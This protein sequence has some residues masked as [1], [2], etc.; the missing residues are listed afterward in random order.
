MRNQIRVK[1]RISLWLVCVM[2]LSMLP[3]NL[4]EAAPGSGS[5]DEKRNK[6][7]E[8]SGFVYGENHL[9]LNQAEVTL[10]FKKS[11]TETATT[12]SNGKFQFSNVPKGNGYKIAIAHEGY[13]T[14][15]Q[16]KIKVKSGKTTVLGTI[17]MTLLGDT[18]GELDHLPLVEAGQPNAVVIV[19]PVEESDENI[20]YAADSLTTYIE[21]STGALLPILTEAELSLTSEY[22]EHIH[23]FVGFASANNESDIQQQLIAMD[24][25]G[26]LIYP[27]ENSVTI[28]GPSS[29]G[30]RFGVDGFLEQYVG[31]RWLMPGEV[32]EDVPTLND[33]S[34][35]LTIV[36]NEPKHMARMISKQTFHDTDVWEKQ[37]DW[38]YHNGWHWNF[39]FH[40]N[41]NVILPISK[42]GATNP[43]FYP[44]VNGQLPASPH[45]GWNPCFT[46]PGIVEESIA[47]IVEYF[48]QHPDQRSYSL[49]VNDVGGFCEADPN[50]PQYPGEY[51]DFGYVDLSNIYYTWVN[52]VVEGVREVHPDKWFGLLAYRE[53]INAPT[54]PGFQ[55]NDHVIPYITSESYAWADPE[56][57]ADRKAMFDDWGQVSENLGWYDYTWGT[58]YML[59][60]VYPQLIGE[61][62]D[63]LNE[64]GTSGIYSEMYPNFAGEGPKPWLFMKLAW[65]P[66]QDVDTLLNEWYQRAVGPEAA[67]DLKAYFD[68]WEQFW[69]ETVPGGR[70]FQ[71]GKEQVYFAYDS[72]EYL[73]MVDDNDVALSRALLESVVDKAQTDQQRARANLFL[74]AFDYYEASALSYPRN[75]EQ[76][77]D[78]NEAISLLNEFVASVETKIQLAETR[79]ALIEA[80]KP[81]PNLNQP[82][83]PEKHGLL[84]SGWNPNALWEV[85]EY[86]LEMEPAGGPVTQRVNEL[87]LSDDEFEA[88]IGELLQAVASPG[89]IPINANPSFEQ[90][91]GGGSDGWSASTMGQAAVIER[92]SDSSAP[93]RS[94]SA[95]VYINNVTSGELKQTISIQPGLVT[96]QL[97]YF[98]PL[99]AEYDL[100][101]IQLVFKY[102]DNEGNV[103]LERGSERE[104]LSVAA[105]SWE[106]LRLLEEVPNR[107]D[108]KIPVQ[109]QVILKMTNYGGGIQQLYVDDAVV[110]WVPNPPSTGIEGRIIGA[111]TVEIVGA[112]VHFAGQT[113]VTDSE[114]YYSFRQVE[115]GNGYEVTV[116]RDGYQPVTYESVTVSVDTMSA[117]PDLVMLAQTGA[118]SGTVVDEVGAAVGG[119]F[120]QVSGTNNTAIADETGSF[121]LLNVPVGDVT[122]TASAPGYLAGTSETVT[123]SATEPGTA[124]VTVKGIDQIDWSE[125]GADSFW[126]LVSYMRTYEP[127]GGSVSQGVDQLAQSTDSYL[128]Q[129]GRLLKSVRP[130]GNPTLN[131]N[132]SFESGGIYPSGWSFWAIPATKYM[133]RV[134]GPDVPI[135]SGGASVMI[136]G[137]TGGGLNQSMGIQPGLLAGQLQFYTSKGVPNTGSVKI[138]IQLY[139]AFDHYL[140]VLNSEESYFA[141]TTGTWASARF[142]QNIPETI[143]VAVPVKMI[144]ILKLTDYQGGVN[145]IFIDDAEFYQSPPLEPSG[146]RGTVIGSDT[147]A[148]AG[149]T[150]SINGQS[151]T[152]DIAGRYSLTG[153]AVGSGYEVVIEKDGYISGQIGSVEIT[154]EEMTDLAAIV[155]EQ[156]KGTINGTVVNAAQAPVAN[157]SVTV[158]GTG[159]LATSDESGNYVIVNVPVG[160]HTVTA[161]APGYVEGHSAVVAVQNGGVHTATVPVVS[162]ADINWGEWD[163][164]SFWCVV[165]YLRTYEPTGGPVSDQADQLAGHSQFDLMRIGQLLQVVRPGGGLPINANPSFETPGDWPPGWS[166]WMV[167]GTAEIKRASGTGVPVYTGEASAW[168]NGSTGGGPNQTMAI[169]PGFLSGQLRYYTS[170]GLPNGGTI[171][172]EAQLFDSSDTLLEVRYSELKPFEETKGT[173]ATLRL[174]E[175][176]P[177]LI[178][179]SPPVK[180]TLIIKLTDASGGVN[181]L[182]IDDAEFYQGPYVEE[183][184]GSIAG[185][186]TTTEGAP[187]PGAVVSIFG[188][189]HTAVTDHAGNYTLTD[190]PPGNY[191]VTSSVA[192]YLTGA[193]A[194]VEVI[195]TVITSANITTSFAANMQWDADLFWN[196]VHYV[197]SYEPSGGPMTSQFAALASSSDSNEQRIGGLLQD[198]GPGGAGPF[199]ANP[200]FEEPGDWPLGWSFWM[201]PVE[202]TI[203][204][205]SGEGVP[206]HTGTASIRVDGSTGG[207]PNQT[208]MIEPGLLAG[209]VYFYTP[210]GVMSSGSIKLELQLFDSQNNLLDVRYSE[211]RPFS[212]SEDQ[213]LALRLFEDIPEQINGAAPVKATMIIKLANSQGGVQQLYMDDAEFYRSAD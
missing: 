2:L 197:R 25:D 84:W 138:E 189:T 160:N 36:K 187:V 8:I 200:S 180:L 192:D 12:D 185:T 97:Y 191:V 171:H 188:T 131:P 166:F 47:V 135:H 48:N 205:V 116:Q 69:T 41:L 118:L 111:D 106:P 100:S 119:A 130:G 206:L 75:F 15:K 46:A 17:V 87:A 1:Q 169:H 59:P 153:I 98:T 64:L 193:Q 176:I 26:Y 190:V 3:T 146:V 114:G 32:G 211:E 90:G 204:R 34:I 123:V 132:P 136:D 93:V 142:L 22:D 112:D 11:I 88:Q 141:H 203:Q 167:P 61:H 104:Y 6:N 122:V 133:Q 37:L 125:W 86:V 73:D 4:V 20:Q 108:G 212:E 39:Q 65:N 184:P 70:W 7:G 80:F 147:V 62:F 196:L 94:G 201:V 110:H 156:H 157:A 209:Q 58:P 159:L 53:V 21:K 172:I 45:S 54:I 128:K 150:V 14:Y 144:M 121:S 13:E 57:E 137:S 23:I 198:A 76:P 183:A 163:A 154:E 126:E 102:L 152:T 120:V 19:P 210:A 207:G 40:H 105:G 194:H 117:I 149:A 89:A 182:F 74:Q 113:I 56:V 49:G 71:Q 55:L 18:G 178:N 68:L 38:A 129:V 28:I 81:D 77:A 30:T 82:N 164:D 79:L 143:G 31:V 83:Y 50:H 115:P 181:E 95:S 27:D 66:E 213:W 67:V 51:N 42:Y 10:R 161:S 165:H 35:P 85:A 134:T 78:G 103:L 177:E 174:L 101:F 44:I 124:A 162:V 52:A 199:N 60:R 151:A 168:I 173:W 96:G 29:F 92:V 208:W 170:A 127:S 195:S 9:P 158:S 24:P 33:L 16:K 107:I 91:T 145:K 72:G 99:S 63:Y 202:S 139:D 140:G 43:E 175:D 186:V 155:L 5:K 179:G 148:I 109:M